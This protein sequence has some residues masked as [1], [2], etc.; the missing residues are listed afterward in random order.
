MGTLFIKVLNMSII[1]GWLV[2]AIVLLRAFFRKIPKWIMC[3][4]WALVA[5]RLL[6]PLPFESVFSLVPSVETVPQDII[7]SQEP[8]IHTGIPTAN[9]VINPVISDMFAPVNDTAMITDQETDM[10]LTPEAAADTGVTYS[11]IKVW[12]DVLGIVWVA[13]IGAMLL[14]ALFSYLKMRRKTAAS[15]LYDYAYTGAENRGFQGNSKK[16]GTPVYECDDIDSPFIL[17]LFRPKIYVPSGM[18]AVTLRSVCSHESAHLRRKDYIWKPLGFMLLSVYWFNPLMWVAYILLSGDIEAACDE[19][20]IENMDRHERAAYSQA[21]LNCGKHE[22]RF[23]VCPLSFGET[24]VKGRVKSILNYKKPAFW[25]IIIALAACVVVGVCFLTNPKKEN[26]VKAMDDKEQMTAESGTPLQGVFASGKAAKPYSE[27][28]E[29]GGKVYV[30]TDTTVVNEQTKLSNDSLQLSLYSDG[31][32]SYSQ[33][34]YS[35][36]MPMGNWYIEGDTLVIKEDMFKNY[37]DIVDGNLVYRENGSSG[38]LFYNFPDGTVFERKYQLPEK[39][40]EYEPAVTFADLSDEEYVKKWYET[41]SNGKMVSSFHYF[42]NTPLD[43][44]SIGL[45]Q[46]DTCIVDFAKTGYSREGGYLFGQYGLEL[47]FGNAYMELKFDLD[48]DGVTEPYV[49]GLSVPEIKFNLERSTRKCDDLGLYD[50]TKLEYYPFDY[51]EPGPGAAYGEAGTLIIENPDGTLTTKYDLA[52]ATGDDEDLYNKVAGKVFSCTDE[53]LKLN[54]NWS[55]TLVLKFYK[56]GTASYNIPLYSS[57]LP[58]NNWY[59]DG[60]YVLFYGLKFKFENGNLV[61]SGLGPLMFFNLLEGMVFKYQEDLTEP[62]S[63]LPGSTQY[64]QLFYDYMKNPS[65]IIGMNYKDVREKYGAPSGSLSGFWGDIYNNGNGETLILYYDGD[66]ESVKRIL[67][68]KDSNNSGYNV[69]KRVLAGK[70]SFYYCQNGGEKELT[71][72]DVPELFTPGNPDTYI[73][74]YT[75]CDLDRSGAEEA[76]LDVI[77][78]GDGG[79]KLILHRMNGLVYAY[80]ADQKRFLELKTDGTYMYGGYG[81]GIEDGYARIFKFGESGYIEEKIS[82][83]HNENGRYEIVMKDVPYTEEKLRNDAETHK[84]KTNSYWYEYNKDYFLEAEPTQPPTVIHS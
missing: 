21:L 69:Y 9:A 48:L 70:E 27:D 54:N 12:T 79:G 43:R 66:T 10:E 46:D 2:L 59:I 58:G 45:Y 39:T 41:R 6:F 18:D 25:I 11:P 15:I 52:K 78:T 75:F 14:F 81:G 31:T 71:I 35:S 65:N 24:G 84:Y 49:N 82:Y 1:A 60:D 4:L 42:G 28:K 64:S 16:S 44:I 55:D 17:G 83:L 32:I 72:D 33:P 77:S 34:I 73:A 20:V 36:H 13:G 3:A 74:Y 50:G 47:I 7:Y 19:K 53:R 68:E 29:I 62:T 61:Y 22:R 80:K 37:F 26:E 51:V 38:F 67:A 23:S 5:V 8:A 30:C 57:I 63:G 56:D 40:H 76:I